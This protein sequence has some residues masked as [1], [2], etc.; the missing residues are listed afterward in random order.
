LGLPVG[1]SE[2]TA[3]AQHLVGLAGER[4]RSVLLASLD[5]GDIRGRVPDLLSEGRLRH[6]A[7]VAPALEFHDERVAWL[8]LWLLI[9]GGQLIPRLD[10]YE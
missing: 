10:D 7:H 8:R 3:S 6:A 4:E 5:L 9:N 2:G 1:S